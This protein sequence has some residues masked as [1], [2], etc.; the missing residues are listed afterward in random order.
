MIYYDL[1]S[2]YIQT[3]PNMRSELAQLWHMPDAS[4]RSVTGKENAVTRKHNALTTTRTRLGHRTSKCM[5]LAWYRT[6]SNPA[7]HQAANKCH[8]ED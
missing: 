2:T 3:I 8:K 4:P 6:T 7:Y 5:P 1:H